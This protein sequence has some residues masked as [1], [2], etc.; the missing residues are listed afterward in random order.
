MLTITP[1]I[2]SMLQ[3][4]KRLICTPMMVIVWELLQLDSMA[5]INGTW[6]V[7]KTL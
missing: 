1:I 7:A 3:K 4:Q 6:Q 2:L 5:I